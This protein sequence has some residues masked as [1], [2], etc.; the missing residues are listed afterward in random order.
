[1]AVK[2]PLDYPKALNVLRRGGSM[3]RLVELA[4]AA[5]A[6]LTLLSAISTTCSVASW[7][8]RYAEPMVSLAVAKADFHADKT[9]SLPAGAFFAR[10]STNRTE[11][12]TTSRRVG[13]AVATQQ[14][15]IL[16]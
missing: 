3:A 12:R 7:A 13:S 16:E 11:S 6:A 5:D 8:A 10:L 15:A 9:A 1:M 4:E 14:N 2:L